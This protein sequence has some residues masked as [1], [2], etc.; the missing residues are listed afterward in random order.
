MRDRQDHIPIREAP[1]QLLGGGDDYEILLTM[2]PEHLDDLARE[3]QNIHLRLTVIGEVGGPGDAFVLL[4]GAEP[5]SLAGAS[6]SHF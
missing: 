5:V 6:F 2:P 3:A 1:S 4:D